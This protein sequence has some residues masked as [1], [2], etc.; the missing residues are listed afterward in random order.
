MGGVHKNM[1]KYVIVKKNNKHS[2][3]DYQFDNSSI[4]F[5][6][7]NG[8]LYKKDVHKEVVYLGKIIKESDNIEEIALE[9]SNLSQK[10]E[11]V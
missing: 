2:L 11:R 6:T 7:L 4:F 5:E 10:K 8:R 9:Y 3:I 1:K